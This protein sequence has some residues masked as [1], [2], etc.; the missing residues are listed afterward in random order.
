M[1]KKPKNPPPPK[2][3]RPNER[4]YIVVPTARLQVLFQRPKQ[5]LHILERE[6]IL[7]ELLLRRKQA[8]DAP[9]PFPNETPKTWLT[10]SDRG[11]F[12]SPEEFAKITTYCALDHYYDRPDS[13]VPEGIPALYHR[14]FSRIVQNHLSRVEPDWRNKTVEMTDA[15]EKALVTDL[16]NAKKRIDEGKP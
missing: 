13:G 2:R 8:E 12:A 11:V 6:S 16:Q 3:L 9:T 1:K 14:T 4:V 5:A 7:Q 10:W 15:Q